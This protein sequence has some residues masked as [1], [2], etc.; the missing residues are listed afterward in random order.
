MT[1]TGR[2]ALFDIRTATATPRHVQVYGF[3]EK[4]YNVVDFLAAVFFLVG[5]VLFFYPAIE[6]LAIWFFVL[7]SALFA[8]RPSVR[9]L[10]EFHLARLPLPGDDPAVHPQTA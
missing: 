5:S 8:A 3:Y 4:L 2:P 10:R 6:V 1:T 7:G 9:V